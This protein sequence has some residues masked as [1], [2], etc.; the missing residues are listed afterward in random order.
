MRVVA[1]RQGAQ[2]AAVRRIR[3]VDAPLSVL[4]EQCLDQLA[5][6]MGRGEAHP[7]GQPGSGIDA[8]TACSMN[9]RT[10]SNKDFMT[11]A[12][13]ENQNRLGPAILQPAPPSG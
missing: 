2:A 13:T 11:P 6:A 3:V 7:G 4:A 10:A 1:M 9:L 5:R 12:C 8:D